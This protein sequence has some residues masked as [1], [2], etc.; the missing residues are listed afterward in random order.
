MGTWWEAAEIV[1]FIEALPRDHHAG[2]RRGLWRNRP[3]IGA[4]A[5][6]YRRGRT[7]SACAPFQRLTGWPAYAAAMPSARPQ[8]IRRLR[9]DPQP[10][11][12]Q[13]HGAGRRRRR[14]RRPGLSQADH[15]AR[16]RPAASASLRSPGKT[17][18][19]P[20]P[21][22]TNFVT[23][24]CGGD[25]AFALKV[26]E[27]CCRATCSS[28]SRWCRCST[29][30]SGS[31]SGAT[32][33][34]TFSPRNCR[35]LAAAR[36]A[37]RRRR[38]LNPPHSSS[39]TNPSTGIS[40]FRVPGQPDQP[41]RLRKGLRPPLRAATPVHVAFQLRHVEIAFSA[42][43]DISPTWGDRGAELG[44]RSAFLAESRVGTVSG[45]TNS[46]AAARS[47]PCRM[48]SVALVR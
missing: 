35:A 13:P 5:A 11:R 23:I 38:L 21:S 48:L 17:G 32:K 36:A 26:L 37:E 3:D 12:R 33:S 47:E 43:P 9:E 6:R 20:I 27:T 1:R 45:T 31:A 7:C 24:D 41:V 44:Q 16:S 42:K 40:S 34:S 30:A 19:T 15:G 39:V 29:A 4:A 22:A 18:L 25:G 14:A 46:V 2:A 8:V 10:L 28:A